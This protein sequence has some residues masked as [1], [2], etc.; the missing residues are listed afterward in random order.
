MKNKQKFPDNLY[1]KNGEKINEDD[2]ITDG[3][4]YYRIYWN[5]AQPQV[6]AYSVAAGYLHNLTPA[7]LATFCRVGT[8]TEKGYLLGED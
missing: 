8:F 2:V 7:R 6:E 5:A 1:D 3:H 4:N